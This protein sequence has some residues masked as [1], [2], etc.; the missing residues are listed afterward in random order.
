MRKI[1]VAVGDKIIG[2]HPDK[3]NRA[4]K[5]LVEKH[6]L[7]GHDINFATAL[8]KQI[9]YAL[10][11]G[12]LEED[13][14]EDFESYIL[15]RL[16]GA[17]SASSPRQE[18]KIKGFFEYGNLNYHYLNSWLSS[19]INNYR[20]ESDR[21][22]RR[23]KLE[24][25]KEEISKQDL[26]GEFLAKETLSKIQEALKSDLNKKIWKL[27]VEKDLQPLFERGDATAL[28][29]ELTKDL[30]KEISPQL[31]T[32]YMKKFRTEFDHALDKV[33]PEL[34]DLFQKYSSMKLMAHRIAVRLL[35]MKVDEE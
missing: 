33:N 4:F 12:K 5:E 18:G 21:Y 1:S 28:S 31:A 27:M 26:E 15:T 29:K 23:H 14:I 22:K 2:L 32:Y 19:Q 25:P 9:K 34:H 35:A 3:L 8:E 24:K 6:D 11:T 17:S 30:G 7:K 20:L 10:E 16:S 13:D